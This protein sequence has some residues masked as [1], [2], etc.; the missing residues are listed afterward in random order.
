VRL[1]NSFNR[2]IIVGIFGNLIGWVTYNLLYIYFPFLKYKIIL[3]WI[4]AYF[5]GVFQQHHFHRK[6]TF[7]DMDKNYFETLIGAYKAYSIGM[8]IST[9]TNYILITDFKVDLQIAWFV[10]VGSSILTNY[11]FLKMAFAEN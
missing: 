1:N 5:I 6:W 7:E 2:Y 4:L 8:V 9:F 10:S 3:V 11:L